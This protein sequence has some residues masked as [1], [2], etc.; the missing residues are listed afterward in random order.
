MKHNRLHQT[1]TSLVKF[2]V[3]IFLL[4]H[5][6]E[7]W[8]KDGMDIFAVI[9]T[10]P[11]SC[12]KEPNSPV[13]LEHS[14][15]KLQQCASF[16][17]AS[18]KE[19]QI[20]KKAHYKA[21]K[22]LKNLPEIMP[23]TAVK[24]DILNATS[25]SAKEDIKSNHL[26]ITDRTFKCSG[27]DN[28][29]D[30]PSTSKAALQA[31]MENESKCN[32]VC[33]S[34]D[35]KQNKGNPNMNLF[36]NVNESIQQTDI[37]EKNRGFQTG[38]GRNIKPTSIALK[39]VQNLLKE[40][41]TD[42][43]QSEENELLI[44]KNKTNLKQC[45]QTATQPKRT[46]QVKE[47]HKISAED[48][49]LDDVIFSE[50]PLEEELKVHT[51]QKYIT[52]DMEKKT[53][54]VNFASIPL[55]SETEGFCTDGGK[56]VSISEKD[57]Q[58]AESLLQKFKSDSDTNDLLQIK[59][60]IKPTVAARQPIM[61]ENNAALKDKDNLTRTET[62][63]S[64]NIAQYTHLR[65]SSTCQSKKTNSFTELS[66][67]S[68]LNASMTNSI[69]ARKNL[70]SLSRRRKGSSL[71][72]PARGT[73]DNKALPETIKEP[74]NPS[75]TTNKLPKTPISNTTLV[76][77][78]PSTPNGSGLLF[79]APA[80][81]TP[82]SEQRLLSPRDMDEAFKPISW[83]DNKSISSDT[84]ANTTF[85]SPKPTVS[86]RIGRLRMYEEPP[87]ISPILKNVPS[88]WRFGGLRRPRSMLKKAENK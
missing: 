39:S 19:I 2:I 81:S 8:D 70:L 29:Y 16:R 54:E 58:V 79:N 14:R 63:Q 7:E 69:I 84:F 23:K 6:F 59:N 4:D 71:I 61:A 67:K 87:P 15:D 57:K 40:F 1:H 38:N 34:T 48:V 83:H 26:A 43:E 82:H 85:S 3:V 76:V 66:V 44:M 68:P 27:I 86:D 80:C 5:H 31:I 32:T 11:Q 30:Q 45:K 42:F 41:Q 60:S 51:S 18:S 73:N 72:S 49:N 52:A 25:A 20:S 28:L 74:S 13:Y 17:T 21:A 64:C 24:G 10:P 78:T 22:L 9:K 12:K 37:P 35:Q 33:D 77:Q 46:T 53:V 47:E 65:A 88:N 75:D 36:S 50:W 56:K 62:A 55:N